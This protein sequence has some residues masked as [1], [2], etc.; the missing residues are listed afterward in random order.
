MDEESNVILSRSLSLKEP[1]SIFRE[2]IES[3]HFDGIVLA[4]NSEF[5]LIN[6]I[7][8]RFYLDGF[9]LLRTSDI[10]D[11]RS[12]KTEIL[13]KILKARKLIV[14][15]LPKIELDDM[16]STLKS[17][18]E[19]WKVISIFCEV[20]DPGIC[21]VGNVRLL[22]EKTAG[23]D[24]IS[25]LGEWNGTTETIELDKITRIDFGGGYEEGLA[26][27]ATHQRKS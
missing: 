20:F 5:T 11:I 12:K 2:N 15:E 18:S 9:V 22:T 8:D 14:Q 16:R 19:R 23:M 27:V 10:T 6:L 4:T 25:P 26:L 24:F 1:I 17:I 13:S 21:V 7:T 3:L